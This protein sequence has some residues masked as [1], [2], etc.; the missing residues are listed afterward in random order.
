MTSINYFNSNMDYACSTQCQYFNFIVSVNF[1]DGDVICTKRK[2]KHL[3]PWRRRFLSP[4]TYN[5]DLT[6]LWIT[7]RVYYK[8]HE[9]FTLRVHLSSST[10]CLVGSISLWVVWSVSTLIVNVIGMETGVIWYTRWMT[11]KTKTQ[12]IVLET[13]AIKQ[14]QLT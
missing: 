8:K 5:T 9:L 7:R 12:H 1:L 11:S 10:V 4:N 2:L 6:W 13:T 14:T 3:T